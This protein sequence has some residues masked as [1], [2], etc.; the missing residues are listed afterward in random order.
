MRPIEVF[1]VAG[2]GHAL[3][4]AVGRRF[5]SKIRRA[6][7]AADRAIGRRLPDAHRQFDAVLDDY[8]SVARGAMPHLADE[9]EGTADGAGISPRA[10]F[11]ANA[12]EE[13]LD[14]MRRTEAA[15]KAAEAAGDR[16]TTVAVRTN[17]SA[18]TGIL[19]HN[20]D[21][22]IFYRP[23]QYA[24]R[25]RLPS[26]VRI[27]A[28]TYAGLIPAIGLNDAGFGMACASV[29]PIDARIGIPRL[30]VARA[31]L[32]ARSIEDAIA[33]A[34]M[35][36]RAGGYG[37][38]VADANGR[39]AWIETTATQGRVGWGDGWSVHTNHYQDPGLARMQHPHT[40]N[41][42]AR[43]ASARKLAPLATDD[44]GGVARM[45]GYHRRG[46]HSICRHPRTDGDRFRFGTI[47]SVILDLGA[48]VGYF[49]TDQPCRG[50]FTRVDL[51]AVTT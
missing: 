31:M 34:T 42:E 41:S 5:Q 11:Y 49:S 23:T 48:R 4:F 3:G 32:E 1:D 26:G 7:R 30:F 8:V 39:T 51:D 43:L 35:P 37:H 17:R 10:L 19:G 45:L 14:G 29:W 20:E 21:V 38:Q 36:D 12:A 47:G 28:Y 50:A 18:P 46:G 24:L 40:A 16:C 33:I 44:I 27:L 13:M 9:V 22:P 15:L 2:E 6:V 25:M